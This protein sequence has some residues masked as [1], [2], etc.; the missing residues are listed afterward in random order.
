MLE[1]DGEDQLDRSVL[2][3][4]VVHASMRTGISYKSKK[5][6]VYFDWSHLAEKLPSKTLL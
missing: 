1:K 3:E 5:K 2:N 6:E 4:E